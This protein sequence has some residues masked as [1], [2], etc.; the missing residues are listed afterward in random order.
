[1]SDAA[2]DP[3]RD[4][5]DAIGQRHGVPADAVQTLLAA[6]NRGGGRQAQ[7]SH[8]ALGGMG[9]WTSGGGIMIGDMFNH[10]LM[11]KIERLCTDLAELVVDARLQPGASGGNWW[12][13]DLGRPSAVGSQNEH[14]YAC[15]PQA[16]RLAIRGPDGVHLYDTADHRILG[17]SQQQSGTR[18]LTFT[19]QHG[20]IRLS[21][22]AQ[23]VNDPKRTD[24]KP[25]MSA[26]N[27]RE[28]THGKGDASSANGGDDVLG[29]LE[30]LHDLQRKGV[31]TPEEYAAKKTE[32]LA[33]L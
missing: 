12:P 33:R 20:T 31:L 1:M 17:V 6:I 2:I 3:S 30:R 11:D 16:R 25:A 15:F 23:A 5:A 14:G 22:L 21:D 8:P 7:F 28:S 18:D 9:Q 32:L 19:S 10:A 27:V 4:E 24:A 29:L 26:A 13:R